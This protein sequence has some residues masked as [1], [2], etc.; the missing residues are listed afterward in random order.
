MRPRTAS[1]RAKNNGASSIVRLRDIHHLLE[2]VS[3][4]VY[5][6]C[7]YEC[8]LLNRTEKCLNDVIANNNGSWQHDVPAVNK[9]ACLAIN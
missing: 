6:D 4:W 7:H 2:N 5:L 8:F 9:P 1:G 3:K